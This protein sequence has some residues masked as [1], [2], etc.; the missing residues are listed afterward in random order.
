MMGDPRHQPYSLSLKGERR[1]LKTTWSL[2]TDGSWGLTVKGPPRAAATS[3][4]VTVTPP[5]LEE[6]IC[7]GG[8]M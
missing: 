7:P 5:N 8:E 4:G 3:L 2:W 6:S 1:N